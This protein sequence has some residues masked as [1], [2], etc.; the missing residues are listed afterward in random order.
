MGSFTHRK[1]ADWDKSYWIGLLPL[2]WEIMEIWVCKCPTCRTLQGEK[3]PFC[4]A[5]SSHPNSQNSREE[6]LPAGLSLLRCSSAVAPSLQ[7][8]VPI[9]TGLVQVAWGCHRPSPKE[10]IW[11]GPL[12]PKVRLG[13]SLILL[14]GACS[15]ESIL[16]II[17]LKYIFLGR[18]FLLICFDWAK[19]MRRNCIPL[20]LVI[21]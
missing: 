21:S 4:C 10:P 15:Q 3:G 9:W 7:P 2:F 5:H 8:D 1:P 20:Q 19:T 11:P 16:R 6:L 17:V 18:M 13:K 12:L 14:N